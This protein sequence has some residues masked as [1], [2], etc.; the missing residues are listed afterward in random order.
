MVLFRWINDV[1]VE[2]TFIGMHAIS[3]ATSEDITS[4]IK[5]ILLR[6]GL[7]LKNCRGQCYDGASVMSGSKSGV[8]T[9]LLQV[10]KLMY[11]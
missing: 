7:D 5:Q 1:Q 2:E 9:R 8:S 4:H 11:L 6:I 3:G 10:S